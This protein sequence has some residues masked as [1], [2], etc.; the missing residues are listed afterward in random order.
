ML[1]KLRKIYASLPLFYSLNCGRYVFYQAFSQLGFQT[2]FGKVNTFC[3]IKGV[4]CKLHW[5]PHF[6]KPILIRVYR[7]F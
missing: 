5:Y 3:L 2:L 7:R 1:N 4:V 6:Q